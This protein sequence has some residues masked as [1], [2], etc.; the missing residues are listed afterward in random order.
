LARLPAH[1]EYCEMMRDESP[2]GAVAAIAED[3]AASDAA[4]DAASLR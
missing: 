2:V 3:A 1:D 4:S